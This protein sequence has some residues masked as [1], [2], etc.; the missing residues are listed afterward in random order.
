[1]RYPAIKNLRKSKYNQGF[2]LIEL[3]ISM[4]LS[5][6]LIAGLVGIF[7]STVRGSADSMKVVNLS[8]ELRAVLEVVSGEI[9]RAGYWSA[10]VNGNMNPHS[11]F[12]VDTTAGS[13]CILYSYDSNDGNDY[14]GFRIRNNA[15]EWKRSNA[16]FAC[17]AANW[18]AIT[19]N[20]VI[21]VTSFTLS[22]ARSQCNNVTS[23]ARACDPCSAAPAPSWIAG[24]LLVYIRLIDITLTASMVADNTVNL[25]L[26]DSVRVRNDEVGT[27]ITNYS[28]AT[29]V[30]GGRLDLNLVM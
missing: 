15:I 1:M 16:Q 12:R 26:S 21:Q 20:G 25:T 5:M 13:E 3:L 2:T 6:L 18:Q 10:P 30:C 8:Q 14:R 27:A 24:D 11:V 19:D 29:H 9:R 17:N 23:A 28:A 7:S 22:S 4:A